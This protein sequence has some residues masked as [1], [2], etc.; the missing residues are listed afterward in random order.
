[1]KRPD[2]L[3]LIVIWQFVSAFMA[4]VG[5]IAIAVFVLPAVFDVAWGNLAIGSTVF[6]GFGLLV[7]LGY[8]GLAVAAGVGVLL[9]KEWGRILAIVHAALSAMNLPVGTV[10][11]VLSLVYLT[12]PEVKAY[13]EAGA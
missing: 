13:F 10:I 12:K 7:L 6:I 8:V 2:L 1:M 5:I 11:G 3:I 9:G 4:G